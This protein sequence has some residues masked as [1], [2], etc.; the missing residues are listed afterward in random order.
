MIDQCLLQV[1]I[2]GHSAKN[3]GIG[4]SNFNSKTIQKNN[5][6]NNRTISQCEYKTIK[7]RVIKL[8]FIKLIQKL[9]Q[10]YRLTRDSISSY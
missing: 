10:P 8:N 3:L 4:A 1:K 7:T 5:N 2:L 6:N 9:E